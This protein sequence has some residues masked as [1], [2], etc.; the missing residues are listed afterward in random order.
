[1]VYLK[2]EMDRMSDILRCKRGR[3]TSSL[4][5]L[6]KRNFEKNYSMLFCGN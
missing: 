3:V 2:V 1:M 5:R 6:V 4:G